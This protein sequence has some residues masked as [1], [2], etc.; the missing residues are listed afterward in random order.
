MISKRGHTGLKHIYDKVKNKSKKLFQIILST[1]R[2][3]EKKRVYAFL[4]LTLVIVI[5][6]LLSKSFYK[7]QTYS[8]YSRSPSSSIRLEQDQVIRFT[9]EAAKSRLSSMTL[10]KD[11][12]KS[13]LGE[14]DTIQITIFDQFGEIVTDKEVFLYHPHRSYVSAVF[15]GLRLNRGEQYVIEIKVS[16]LSP[17]S[18]LYL[19]MHSV[20]LFDLSDVDFEADDRPMGFTYVPNISYRYSVISLLSVSA[21]V[22]FLVLAALIL[23]FDRIRKSRLFCELYRAGIIVMFLYLFTE[24]LNIARDDSLQFL[25]PF[26]QKSVILI[27]MALLIVAIIYAALYFLTS[28]GTLAIILTS[29]LIIALGY[30]NHSKIVMRGDPLVPWD[31]FAAGVAAKCSSQYDFR[32][33][34]QFVS[35]FFLIA[36]ILLMIRLTHQPGI[37]SI[38]IRIVGFALTVLAGA[39][40]T[41]GFILNKPLH[42]KMDISYSLY[43]PLESFNENGTILSFFLHFNNIKPKGTIDNS[44]ETTADIIRKYIQ[45]GDELDLDRYVNDP[46]IQPNVIVIMSESYGDL[47]M[48]R[49]FDTSEPVMPY[50]DSILEDTLHGELQVSVFAGGTSNTEFEFQTGYSVS[51]LLAGSSVYTFYVKDELETAMPFLFRNA[52][53]HT[54]ALHPFDAQWWDRNS[55]YP[56]LGFNEFI[57]QEKFVDPKIIRRFI[58]DESAF[59]RIIEEYEKTDKDKPLFAFCVTMQNH[60]DYS[61]R[62]DNQ[63]YDIKFEGFEEYDFPFAENYMSLLRESDDAL[64]LLID[65]FRQVQEPTMIVFFGDHLP[66]L[67]HGLYDLLLDTDINNIT[68][69]ESLPLYSTPY[70]IWS[71]YDL[72]VGYA[73]KT[74]PNF[75]GQTV[76]DLAGI[77]SPGQRACLRVL[78]EKISAINALAIFDKEGMAWTNTDNMDEEI[79]DIIKD[80]ERIQ[81]GGIFYSDEAEGNDD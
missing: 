58:S 6:V 37:R 22:A 3:L 17:E 69:E 25:F 35:S 19:K 43:P 73:G 8:N 46:K 62:W 18:V 65:Y 24:M 78:K 13:R 75:L 9:F 5:S 27:I 57:D 1:D 79:V 53:Y 70:F 11:A 29:V 71:N 66:T 45:I 61:I 39:G 76:L 67:D 21:H 7:A 10:D 49:D 42:E 81:Y 60:A 52:G 64:K 40:L 38:R 68:K 50:Y 14:T 80:Y 4:C 47:R 32:V 34:V 54:V 2:Y 72:P 56:N 36:V 31:I 44:P 20:N 15:S 26:N 74:S 16:G 12:S 48:I 63:K 30:V 55:A 51:G 28:S 41:F 77:K 23:F 59:I 33:T